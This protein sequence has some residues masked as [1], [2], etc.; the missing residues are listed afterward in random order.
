MLIRHG[1][2]AWS[3]THKHTGRTDVPLTE[4]GRADARRLAPVLADRTFA[5]ILVS[6]L[7]RAVATAELA[8]LTGAGR[9]ADMDPD[10]VEWDYGQ[11]EGI[12][13]ETY[14]QTHA[15]WLLW[16]DGCPGGETVEHVGARADRVLDRCATIKGDVALVAHGHLLRILTAHYLRLPAACGRML[17]LDPATLST[18]GYEREDPVILN[19]NALVG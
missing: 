15:G 9:Q 14:R 16:D 13:T 11:V 18:L 4:A 8:G 12:S 10:L 7:R 6:P 1:E 19:W 3:R 17:A 5:Q 2:T